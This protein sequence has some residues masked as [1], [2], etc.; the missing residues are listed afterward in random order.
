MQ[1]YSYSTPEPSALI[2]TPTPRKG[3]KSGFKKPF[4]SGYDDK[5]K[6]NWRSAP[7]DKDKLKCN[8]C[9][10]MRHIKEN[11]WDLVGCPKKISKLGS[12]R[13]NSTSYGSEVR[14][15]LALTLLS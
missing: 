11:R 10:K 15:K 12:M 6:L 8:H 5:E 1:Q 14:M 3:G 2:S 13:A 4:K 9:G 7:V